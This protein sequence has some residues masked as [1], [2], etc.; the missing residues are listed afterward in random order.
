MFHSSSFSSLLVL[1]FS[2]QTDKTNYLQ[3]PHEHRAQGT[4]LPQ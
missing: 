1:W 2:W 4:L 3:S